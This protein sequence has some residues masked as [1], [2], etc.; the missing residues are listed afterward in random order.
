MEGPMTTQRG[1]A[2]IVMSIGLGTFPSSCSVDG[3]GDTSTEAALLPRC[4][5]GNPCTLDG[6]AHRRCTHTP[7]AD[8]TACGTGATCQAGAC[9]APAPL[10]LASSPDMASAE[11]LSSVADL[12]A[13]ADA[14]ALFATPDI[15]D[16]Q[17]FESGWG[18]FTDWG[19]NTPKGATRD[20]TLAYEGSWSV[21]YSWT[22]NASADT[23]SQLSN[24]WSPKDRVWVRFYFRITNH[25]S[26]IW[27]FSRLYDSGGFNV[28]LGGVFVQSGGEFLAWG[29]DEE[30][31]SIV[32]KIGVDESQ[33]VDGKWHSLEYDYWRNGDPSG[34]PSVAFWFDGQPQYAELDGHATIK[35]FGAGNRSYWSNGRLYAGERSSSSS[36]VKLGTIEWV[37]TLN[38]GNSTSGQCNLD[39]IAV[40]SIGHIGP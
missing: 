8:G 5:D 37:G 39:R 9:V 31:A 6:S 28:G 27:K 19:G 26:T 7:V 34:Y 15:V 35:Y 16:N 3:E 24:S 10:D 23:G 22:P 32:T 25:I 18:P 11:D 4:D 36:G 20:N 13:S 12:A 21:K 17:G 2:T 1:W 33:V 14:G 29:W 30:D 38:M 40:S